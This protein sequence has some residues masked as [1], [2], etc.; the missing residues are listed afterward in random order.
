MIKPTD[1]MRGFPPPRSARPPAMEWDRHPWNRWSFR[2][3]REIVPTAEVWRGRGPVRDLPPD[4]QDI[5]QITFDAPDGRMTV[6]EFLAS[7]ETDG[8]LI[9]HRGRRVFENYYDGMTERSL[10]LSQSLAKS[11]VGALA[12]SL[13]GDGLIDPDQPVTSLLPEFSETA[14][15]GASIR[16]LLDMTSGVFFDE[17]YTNPRSGMGLIDVGA[18]WKPP[19][20]DGDW[21]DCVFDVALQNKT[22]ARP[23]GAAF[24]Y[25]SIETDVLA[26]CLER[27]AGLRLPE[28]LSQR[29]WTR[30][31]VEESASFTIDKAGYALADG[32]FNATLRDYGRFGQL[33]LDGG[34]VGAEQV[35]PAKWIEDTHHADPS[36]FGEPY[37]RVLP[38]GGYRNSFWVE[39]TT[40]RTLLC[41]GVFGQLI[42]IAPEYD[43]VGVKLSSWPEFVSP[44]R[45]MTAIKAM[46]AIGQGLTS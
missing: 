22:L 28:L 13:V 15:R 40:R 14:Y 8:F 1:I 2:N 11:I 4:F 3:M 32:G 42:F 16:H 24:D 41:R 10:H 26:F 46:H 44:R 9:L 23:H 6:T 33:I 37:N 21:P 35:L 17:E 19:L 31:G 30:L 38:K 12:G 45:T 25:R 20:D 36:V 27:A 5:G 7:S 34:R 18:G 43:M 29:L 39:D